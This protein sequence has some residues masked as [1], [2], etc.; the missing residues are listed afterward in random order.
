MKE[1]RMMFD[2]ETDLERHQGFHQELT[3][4]AEGA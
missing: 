3:F 4:I 2:Q 1:A